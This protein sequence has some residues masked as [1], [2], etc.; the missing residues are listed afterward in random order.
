MSLSKPCKVYEVDGSRLNGRK[1]H[2]M[3]GVVVSHSW[4]PL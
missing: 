3:Q 2:D 1:A 4:E